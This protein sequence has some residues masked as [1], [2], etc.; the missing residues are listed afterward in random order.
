MKTNTQ[1]WTVSKERESM[2]IIIY[3]FFK[4][5]QTHTGER[6]SIYITKSEIQ[7]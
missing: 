2:R 6:R 3:V 4:H 1:I 7:I 5:K